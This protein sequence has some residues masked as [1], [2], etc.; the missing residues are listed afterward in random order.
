MRTT[1]SNRAGQD[2]GKQNPETITTSRREKIV[3][4]NCSGARWNSTEKFPGKRRR[5]KTLRKERTE[6]EVEELSFSRGN[7]KI[8]KR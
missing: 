3:L 6:K 2:G 5:R 8:G 4:V 1:L 7:A